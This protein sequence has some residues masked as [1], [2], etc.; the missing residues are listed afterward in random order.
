M[1]DILGSSRI[2]ISQLIRLL[3]SIRIALRNI[4]YFRYLKSRKRIVLT[5][6]EGGKNGPR[7]PQAIRDQALEDAAALDVGKKH[8]I[9]YGCQEYET[10]KDDMRNAIRALKGTRPAEGRVNDI[11]VVDPK[12]LITQLRDALQ[13]AECAYDEK[14]YFKTDKIVQAALTSAKAFIAAK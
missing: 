10:G 2:H 6:A 3:R 13:A 9:Y 14:S 7:H 11:N 5:C 8:S 12:A 4:G 1:L